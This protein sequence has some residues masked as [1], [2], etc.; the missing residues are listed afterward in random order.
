MREKQDIH[1]THMIIG[2]ASKSS[3]ANMFLCQQ[4][5]VGQVVLCS[6]SSDPFACAPATRKRT[7]VETVNNISNGGFKLLGCDMT[8]VDGCQHVPRNFSMKMASQL[9]RSQMTGIGKR[10]QN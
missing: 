6:I 3:I 2:N 7:A 9:I 1:I 8:T 5:F 10:G 4:V